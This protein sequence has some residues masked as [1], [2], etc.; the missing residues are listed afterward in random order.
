MAKPTSRMFP[1]VVIGK[2]PIKGFMEFIE[3]WKIAGAN[4]LPLVRLYIQANRIVING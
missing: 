4:I 1:G 3:A 2:I